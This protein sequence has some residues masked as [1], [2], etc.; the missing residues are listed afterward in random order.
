MKRFTSVVASLVLAALV[1]SVMAA[2]PPGEGDSG[3]VGSPAVDARSTI[4]IVSSVHEVKFADRIDFVLT[5]ESESP[6][7]TITFFYR[8][9][10]RP[11][12][13]YGYPSFES[14]TNVTAEFSID[15]GR[16]A[17]IPSGV[18]IV[19]H[20]VIEDAD[21]NMLES[22]QR[23]LLYLDPAFDWR[24]M[25]LDNIEVMWHDRPR[26]TVRDT[27]E[28]V[29]GRLTDIRRVLGLDAAPLMRAV[30]LNNRREAT[31]SFPIISSAATDSHLYA[32]FAYGEYDLFV[33]VGLGVEGM[34]HEM[35]HLLLDEAIVS[36]LGRVPAW[37]NEGLA[38]YFESS[39]SR[40]DVLRA[41]RS[42]AL[43]PLTAMR[44]Q[45][46][47]PA[48]VRLFYAQALSLV[49]Y[50][51]E[52]YGEE[53]VTRVVA[54]LSSGAR[55]EDAI[56]GAYERPLDIIDAE[57]RASIGAAPADSGQTAPAGSHDEDEPVESAPSDPRDDG[58]ERSFEVD[59]GTFGT[60]LLL[61][62]AFAFAAAVTGG[63]WLLRRRR[64][65]PA[66]VGDEPEGFDPRYDTPP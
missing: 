39:P 57:W 38:Q 7:R 66:V 52:T 47:R 16:S 4:S 29:D 18:E 49:R 53:T 31:R 64:V 48:D 35:T 28:Q 50:M 58:F 26:D 43:L 15:T 2:A 21:G 3:E 45:P 12:S 61:A 56:A 8:L 60:S 54:A 51:V 33:L 22:E 32:G 19:Y 27:A 63:G 37:Y 14:G 25:S 55:F 40:T 44:G 42:G 5:A 13:V 6:I 11:I 36:P 41:A 9:G 10:S 30:I 20:Y 1:G 34:V 65:V 24:V 23:R 59:P 62:L 17:Y 46:G